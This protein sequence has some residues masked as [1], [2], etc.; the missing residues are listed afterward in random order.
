MHSKISVSA[1]GR[2][3]EMHDSTAPAL[4][5]FDIDGTLIRRAGIY[6]RDALV[7]AIRRVTGFDTTTDG[8]PLYG[9]LD[10]DII[11]EMLRRAGAPARVARQQM[12]GIMASAGRIYVRTCP[13]LT[14]KTCPGVRR[15]LSNLERRGIAMALV[16]G[17]LARIGWWKMER[18]GL[19]RYFRF[20]AFSE[21]A[22]DRAGLVRIAVRQAR[23]QGWI[24]R[25]TP[26]CLIGDA[27][28]DILAARASGVRSIAVATGL[29]SSGKLRSFG[30]DLVLDD[31]R[32]LRAEMLI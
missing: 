11:R 2:N 8:I 18:A 25:N 1:A 16:T 13:V 27:P 5:L 17:N 31:L 4:A 7:Q 28:A 3:G 30:P 14:R 10:P 19:R 15:L 12:P 6:H 9:M 21:M 24:G 23:R 26:V 22:R 29:V 20:G 32:A